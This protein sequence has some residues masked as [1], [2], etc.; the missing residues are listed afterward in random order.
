VSGD[1]GDDRL[2]GG[3]GFD[4]LDGNSGDDRLHGGPGRNRIRGG[5]D[6]DTIDAANGFRD[7]VNCGQGRDVGRADGN[8]R[9][10]RCEVVFRLRRVG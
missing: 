10:R 6:R 3:A 8:D 4:R 2:S 1:S 9:L 7:V 5:K